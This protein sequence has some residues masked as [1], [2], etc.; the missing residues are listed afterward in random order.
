MGESTEE[1]ELKN[2]LIKVEELR[3]K[4]K[5]DMIKHGE[6]IEPIL[7]K[8]SSWDKNKY[9]KRN[10]KNSKL[11]FSKPMDFN[12]PFDTYPVLD[13]TSV[14]KQG[15]EFI[16]NVFK[17][18]LPKIS[19]DILARLKEINI[20]IDKIME[21]FELNR[22]AS[23]G[24]CC[25]TTKNDNLLMWAHYAD[26]HKGIC[27]GFEKNM[28]LIAD[29]NENKNKII[30]IPKA[31]I[32]RKKRPKVDFFRINEI[33]DSSETNQITQ[34]LYTKS[35]EWKYE[36]EY[37]CVSMNYIGQVSYNP[38]NLKE[39]ILGCKMTDP[40]KNEVRKLVQKMQHPPKIYEARLKKYDYGL[41]IIEDTNNQ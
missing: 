8:Y 38:Y 25:F 29:E 11:Y 33:N 36:D 16:P 5:A 23:D 20:P 13:L 39:I 3:K 9:I 21:K 1:D 37:R 7:Y 2:V 12:D 28:E 40:K 6:P 22:R 30:T 32:Y 14:K 10:I 17:K 41:E 15:E 4:Y 35:K 18:M 19:E 31:V 34:A 27:L 26:Y 24:V